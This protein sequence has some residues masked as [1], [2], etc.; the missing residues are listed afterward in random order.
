LFAPEG[1]L[2]A[3]ITAVSITPTGIFFSEK[4][5]TVRRDLIIS[6][7]RFD[8]RTIS[9]SVWFLNSNFWNSMIFILVFLI[10]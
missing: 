5:R 2:A 6:K 10:A 7:K 4:S 8:R 3:A 9:S 1:A